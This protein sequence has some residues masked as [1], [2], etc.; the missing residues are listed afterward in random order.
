[1]NPQVPVKDL[2]ELAA[3]AKAAEKP[4][5]Y[6]STGPGSIMNLCGELFKRDAGVKMDHIPFRG[7]A[8]LVTDMLAG[9]IQFGGD[10]LSSSLQHVR[11]G[12]LKAVG[13][14]SKSVALPQVPTARELGFPSL[15]FQGWNGFLAAKGTPEP[16]VARLQQVIA[17]GARR[18]E[19]AK[20]MT[21]VG[22]EPSGS[23]QAEMAD[24][25]AKQIA[26]VRP[27]VEELK[28]LVE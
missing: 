14:A 5:L 16:I 26:Q 20:R 21:D 10:Q 7:A 15:E 4:L 23:T 12:S 18:P 27:A 3:H 6:G 25:L 24:M 11:A 13:V 2:K 22:A 17:A 19:I 8:P 9:R 28:L 1:V